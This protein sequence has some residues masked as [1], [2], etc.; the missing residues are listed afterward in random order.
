MILAP[1]LA[2]AGLTGQQDQPAAARASRVQR[3]AQ[4]FDLVTASDEF[5][6]SRDHGK[7]LPRRTIM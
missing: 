1:W 3:R 5:F 6:G 4:F 2:D 7:P